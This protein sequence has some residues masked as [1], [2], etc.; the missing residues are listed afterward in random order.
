MSKKN[1]KKQRAYIKLKP[2]KSEISFVKKSKVKFI[3]DASK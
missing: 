2:I 1:K 3:V